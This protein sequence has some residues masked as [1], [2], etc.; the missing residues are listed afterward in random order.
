MISERRRRLEELYQAALAQQPGERSAFLR[1]A[2]ADDESLRAEIETLL[3]RGDL[4]R[5]FAQPGQMFGNYRIE[6]TLGHGGMGVVFLAYDTTLHRHVALKLVDGEVDSDTARARVL[7]EARNAAAL[8]HPN[9]CTIHEVGDARGTAFIAMEY[10]DGRSLSD[11]LTERALPLAEVLLY[12]VQAADAL[13]HAHDHGVVHRDFKAANAIVDKANRLKVVDF[14][15]SRRRD[16][17]QMQATTLGSI[18]DGGVA[19][20][21]YAMAP[22]QVR[23][24]TADARTDI[25]ALGVLLYEMAGGRKPFDGQTVPELLSSILRDEPAPL[26]VAVPAPLRSVIDRCL[27]KDPSR[28]YQN[29]TEVRAALETVEAD[30]L[31]PWLAWRDGIRRRPVLA[32]AAAVVVL[33]GVLAG[34]SRERIRTRWLGGAPR[35]DSLAVLPLENLSGDATQDYF[36]DGM[37]EV[38]STDLA[39]LGGLKR[40]TARGSVIRYKGTTKPLG[41]IARELNVDALVTGSVQRSGNRVSITAQ[42]LDPASGDQLWTDRYERDLQDVLVLRNEIVSAIV[43]EIK[44]HLSPVEQRRLASDLR[45]NPDA[46]EA[47]LKGRF[48]WYRQTREDY[49]QAERYF[50][51]AIDKDPGYALAYAGLG[52]VWMMRG[53]AGFRPPSETAPKARELMAK[54]LALDDSLADIHVD[55]GNQKATMLDWPGAEREYRRALELNPNLADAHFFYSDLLLTAL[56]RQEDWNREMQ[57]ALELDPLNDFNRSFYG[58]H[59]NYRHR[60]DEAIAIFRSLLPGGPNKAS[61]YLGLWG[62][63]FRKGQYAEALNAAHEYFVAAG[64]GEFAALLGT[65]KDRAEYRAAMVRA[66][67][68]MAARSTSRHVPAIRIG[69]MFAHAGD[70]DRAIR[71]LEQAERNRESALGRL[72]VFWDWDDL[73]SDARF[74]DLLGRLNL[75]K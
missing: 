11:R 40:V 61:N 56:N 50:Q 42:L 39:R 63:H 31:K 44:A 13:A 15:L 3:T 69:R 22:E 67:E 2:C 30:A 16:A 60:Y 52:S 21:P 73:R 32:S 47:Y 18:V 48:Y 24:E 72:A 27:E 25:W 29:A 17:A 59:L 14:G 26:S 4:S 41:E 71:W 51:S 7:R 36:A 6:R 62:A 65:A 12:G 70:S 5:G 38:L 75:P 55:L 23:G 45:V 34:V 53:D 9:I 10:V 64:D 68:A 28:R 54:A 74:Q 57:R 58:W 20:T 33:A 37:T 43:R 19:G 49:D 1:H 35:V 66:G 46:F 8:N